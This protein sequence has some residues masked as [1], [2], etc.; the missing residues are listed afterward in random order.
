ML[1]KNVENLVLMAI[2]YCSSS[3]PHGSNRSVNQ[4]N[5]SFVGDGHTATHGAPLVQLPLLLVHLR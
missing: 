3:C 1:A 5:L 4:E 2:R